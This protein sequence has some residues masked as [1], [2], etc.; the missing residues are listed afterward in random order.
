MQA[1]F[2]GISQEQEAF[3]CLSG[4]Q[5]NAIATAELAVHNAQVIIQSVEHKIHLL[6]SLKTIKFSRPEISIGCREW[7][8]QMIA[9]PGKTYD[10]A[11]A[12]LKSRL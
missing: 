2:V 3:A 8:V 10:A 7:A 12:I 1:C 9:C 5:E 4:K 6:K 11:I